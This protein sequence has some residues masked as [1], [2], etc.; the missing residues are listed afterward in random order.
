MN[1]SILQMLGGFIRWLIKG[2]KTDLK[3]EVSG[4]YVATWGRSYEMEN[5]AIGMLVGFV[6]IATIIV[7]IH[8][9]II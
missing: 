4:K 5:L 1:Y 2:C 8:Y 3:K 9:N 6:F 7:L